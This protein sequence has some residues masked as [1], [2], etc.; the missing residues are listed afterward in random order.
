MLPLHSQILNVDISHHFGRNL[1]FWGEDSKET[2]T[3]NIGILEYWN[4]VQ[5]WKTG[6]WNTALDSA[7]TLGTRILDNSEYTGTLEYWT[8]LDNT[9]TLNAGKLE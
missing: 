7:A 9:R 1:M 8:A 4:I 5:H 6:K 3:L 2:R